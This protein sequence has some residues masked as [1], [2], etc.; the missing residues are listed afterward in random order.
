MLMQTS[1]FRQG[2]LYAERQG[3]HLPPSSPARHSSSSTSDVWNT[4]S[5]LSLPSPGVRLF[6]TTFTLD[7]PL[8]HDIALGFAFDQSTKG[9]Y[10]I[11]LYVNGWQFG[12]MA[13]SVGPQVSCPLPPLASSSSARE[14]LTRRAQ[15]VFPVPEGVLEHQGENSVALSMW[16]YGTNATD[17]VL[18]GVKLQVLKALKGGIGKVQLV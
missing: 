14:R 15:T 11:Q 9:R 1:P 4:T 8:G 13:S 2:G 3:Y 7:L 6:K 16:A 12:K 17:L 5:S 18:P 10:R